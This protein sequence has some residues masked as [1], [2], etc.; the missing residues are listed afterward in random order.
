MIHIIRNC[1][2]HGVET[3][4]ARK[5]S[6][7]SEHGTVKL[8]AFNS[9]TYVNIVI[10]DDG[11]GIDKQ[12]VRAKAIENGII[13]ASATLTDDEVLNL[14]FHPGLS[15]ASSVSDISGRGVGMD[16][17]RQRIND[18]R[19]FVSVQSFPGK[20]TSFHLKLPLSR[21]IIDG[22]LVKVDETPY[23]IPLNIVTR[24]DRINYETLDRANKLNTS[25][26]VNEE[27]VSVFSLRESF[28]SERPAPK[29]TDIISVTINGS[30]R[31][32]AVDRIEGKLQTVMK[33]LGDAFLQQDFIAGST[34]LG[35]GSLALVLDP[36]RLFQVTVN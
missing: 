13:D 24:I 32:I 7:K 10:S 23:V 2:D 8:K 6:G 28:H 3:P 31:A 11:A 12:K 9:S 22:L 21:S 19:G 1:I 15:T 26:V 4:E 25:V 29:T 35:D 17:V 16:V 33:P 27:L 30:R 20:G 34:I 18:L 14:I 5:A 36:V